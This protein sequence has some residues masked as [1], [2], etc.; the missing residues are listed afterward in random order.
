MLL[1]GTIRAR[2]HSVEACYEHAVKPVKTGTLL[3]PC[4]QLTQLQHARPKMST[5]TWFLY[6]TCTV[7]HLWEKI[8]FL[9]LIFSK[10]VHRFEIVHQTA[11]FSHISWLVEWEWTM[12][13]SEQI[14]G[15]VHEPAESRMVEGVSVVCGSETRKMDL[16]TSP[17][18]SLRMLPER[19]LWISSKLIQG[20]ML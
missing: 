20:K 19:R 18:P 8:H 17:D 1:F 13:T 3:P 2:M 5:L 11:A 7:S 6:L 15:S 14:I 4:V 12:T 10:A 16:D 9:H